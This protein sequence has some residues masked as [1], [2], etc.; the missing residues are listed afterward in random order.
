MLA[1]LLPTE[2]PPRVVLL[3]PAN[4]N[5]PP[6]S[7]V[8]GRESPNCIVLPLPS[9]SVLVPLMANA[10][11]K[12][13]AARALSFEAMTGLPATAVSFEPSA[14]FPPK[15]ELREGL[16]KPAMVKF[17]L[18]VTAKLTIELAPAA[19]F[20]DDCVTASIGTGTAP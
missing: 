4:D 13:L 19:V 14:A 12:E 6:P 16:L 15:L 9:S 2:R 7:W 11:S 5:W 18:P 1:L 3:N 20:P 17:P 10:L 8:T